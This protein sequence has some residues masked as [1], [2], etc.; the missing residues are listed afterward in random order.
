M[1]T[2]EVKKKKI[3][4]KEAK[5]QLLGKVTHY[6]NN[7]KVAIIKLKVDLK[8]GAEI[9]IVGANTDFKQLVGS[10]QIEHEEVKKAKKGKLIGLKVKKKVH[11]DNTVYLVK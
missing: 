4:K 10:M 5:E 9:H 1:K 8:T 11:E 7:I 2:K 6:Y 3:V